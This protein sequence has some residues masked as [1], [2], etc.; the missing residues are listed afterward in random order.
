M[1]GNRHSE[2]T[3]LARFDSATKLVGR[4]DGNLDRADQRT[5]DPADRVTTPLLTSGIAASSSPRAA[6]SQWNK[7]TRLA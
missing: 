6:L 2:P 7:D 1:G 3:A 5:L 4:G